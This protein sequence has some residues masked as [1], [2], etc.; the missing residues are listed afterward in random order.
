MYFQQNTRFIHTKQLFRQHFHTTACLSR[1]DNSILVIAHADFWLRAQLAD[2][3]LKTRDNFCAA[4]WNFTPTKVENWFLQ[5]LA[6]AC[7]SEWEQW[8][9]RNQTKRDSSESTDLFI[10][11]MS[12]YICAPRILLLLFGGT[13]SCCALMSFNTVAVIVH[14]RCG[15][16][17]DMAS[18]YSALLSAKGSQVSPFAR[19]Q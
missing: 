13:C 17:C 16:R 2:Q 3:L 11:F 7:I 14:S 15:K 12:V 1:G 10:I 19:R 4:V 8:R 18:T 9:P 5:P 6:T